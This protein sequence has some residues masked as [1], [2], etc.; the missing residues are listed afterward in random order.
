MGALWKKVDEK[1][2]FWSMLIGGLKEGDTLIAGAQ[3]SILKPPAT[4]S[5]DL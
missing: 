1:A 2:A 4:K 3:K 5:L